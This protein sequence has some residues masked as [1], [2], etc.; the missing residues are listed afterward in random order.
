MDK[1][2]GSKISMFTKSCFYRCV[3]ETQ[4]RSPPPAD[5]GQMPRSNGTDTRLASGSLSANQDL[6]SMTNSAAP[7]QVARAAGHRRLHSCGAQ[8]AYRL[9]LQQA[10]T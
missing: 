2:K 8:R 4:P 10:V 5:G 6:G 3:R 7:L 1:V 9:R